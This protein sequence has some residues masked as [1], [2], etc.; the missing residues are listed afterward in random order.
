MPA[1]CG[2][3]AAAAPRPKDDAKWQSVGPSF[4]HN[5]ACFNP[6]GSITNTKSGRTFNRNPGSVIS[7]GGETL[8]ISPDGWCHLQHA[9]RKVT[10]IRFENPNWELNLVEPPPL[11][12]VGQTATEEKKPELKSV[13][14]IYKSVGQAAVEEQIG[15]K[16]NQGGM[17][18]FRGKYFPAEGEIDTEHAGYR[19]HRS[20]DS[21]VVCIWNDAF[22]GLYKHAA[23]TLFQRLVLAHPVGWFQIT[24]GAGKLED[25][26]SRLDRFIWSWTLKGIVAFFCFM[27]PLVAAP[28][29]FP[30]LVFLHYASGKGRVP[31]SFLDDNAADYFRNWAV[32][33]HKTVESGRYFSAD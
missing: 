31:K 24:Y 25:V 26:N 13:T 16:L 21:T 18:N 28:F 7:Q 29:L 19:I 5:W 32:V 9:D 11:P 23:P 20:A 8:S 17:F 10:W 14:A 1:R 30:L 6:D 22:V 4:V 27:P 2:T 33:V 3:T 15:L 12:T